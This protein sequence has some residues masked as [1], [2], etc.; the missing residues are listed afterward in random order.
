MTAPSV[1]GVYAGTLRLGEI[2]DRGPGRVE[3]WLLVDDELVPLGEHHD[4]R[5]GMRAVSAAAAQRR[6]EQP[7][8]WQS[9]LRKLP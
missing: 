5:A 3:A 6:Q 9:G 7:A 8:E 4:R 1:M 2:I